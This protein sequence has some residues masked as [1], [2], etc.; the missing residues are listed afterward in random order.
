MAS[1][2]CPSRIPWGSS[3]V[4]A[5]RV[6]GWLARQRAMI[7][8]NAPPSHSAR[9]SDFVEFLVQKTRMAKAEINGG[10]GGM[11]PQVLL[12]P[13]QR[14]RSRDAVLLGLWD[15]NRWTSHSRKPWTRR[16]EHATERSVLYDLQS[17]SVQKW[18][19]L[20][21]ETIELVYSATLCTRY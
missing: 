3:L 10:P 2:P 14:V 9:C 8:N 21:F 15:G 12:R 4:S 19:W 13:R 6:L 11:N 5:R 16:R 18:S 1:V 7:G 20:P 17:V